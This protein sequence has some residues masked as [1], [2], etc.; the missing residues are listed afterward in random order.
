M[1]L[2]GLCQDNGLAARYGGDDFMVILPK[3]GRQAAFAFA[4]S[5]QGWLSEKHFLARGSQRIPISVS[6]G[7]AVFP[8]DGQ[9]RHELVAVADANLYESKRWGGESR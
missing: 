8:E 6:C 3:A 1:N 7:V 2:A 5:V 9:K 4:Q